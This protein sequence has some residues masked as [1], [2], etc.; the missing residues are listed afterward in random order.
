[1]TSG[2]IANL[3]RD[4]ATRDIA[5]RRMRTLSAQS[6]AG[7]CGVAAKAI[8]PVRVRE[9]RETGQPALSRAAIVRE[10]IA[11]LDADGI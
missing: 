4:P 10:A 1:M 9:N 3:L 6:Q 2:S 8:K 11:V 7:R 5:G